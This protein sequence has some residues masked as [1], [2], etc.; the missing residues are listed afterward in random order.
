MRRLFLNM[1]HMGG[2]LC[3]VAAA[4]LL[5]V[6]VAH[7]ATLDLTDFT[8]GMTGN[9]I[10]TTLN[11]NNAK[12]EGF[13]G[14]GIDNTNIAPGAGITG[15][16]LANDT[17]TAQQI[18]TGAVTTVEILDST[19]ASIDIGADV[20]LAA[21]IATGAVTTVEI[22]NGTILEEDIASGV[23]PV[24]DSRVGYNYQLA[25]Q[26]GIPVAEKNVAAPFVITGLTNDQPKDIVY[27]GDFLYVVVNDTAS[28]DHIYKIN[29]ATMTQVGG[30]IN[31]ASSD[32][33]I[34][35][36]C[37]N[38][39]DI[40]VLN[41]GTFT[42]KRVTPGGTVTTLKDLN[43]FDNVDS[44]VVMKIDPAGGNVLVAAQDEN[45]TTDDR[46]YKIQISDGSTTFTE[47]DAGVGTTDIFDMFMAAKGGAHRLYL[48]KHNAGPVGEIYECDWTATPPS[49]TEVSTGVLTLSVLSSEYSLAFD[50]ESLY[51]SLPTA[52]V[53][54]TTRRMDLG[55]L[56]VLQTITW[57]DGNTEPEGFAE[58]DFFDGRK[59]VIQQTDGLLNFIHTAHYANATPGASSTQEASIDVDF[60]AG[61]ANP[62]PCGL[63]G[64]GDFLYVCTRNTANTGFTVTKN[65]VF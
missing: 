63:A 57:S 31:L 37:H 49:C 3:W 40:F 26:A 15:D 35:V 56:L 27:C 13:A 5:V 24:T 16:K 6:I 7:A 25:I 4:L 34:D 39:G 64:D 17:I 60:R 28:T 50:G 19:I 18:A 45:S 14:S 2:F 33:P 10:M 21:D 38:S 8:S 23:I 62:Y 32:D 1:S 29:P 22:L 58:M 61:Q 12:I 36:E 46:L 30:V 41:G 11:S 42:V 65:M 47:V 52:G 54:S 53:A 51:F 59:I 44:V 48:F 55:S 9:T 20:I 43:S